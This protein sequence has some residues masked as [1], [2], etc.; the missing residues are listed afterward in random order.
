MLKR[1]IS[2]SPRL[3]ALKNDTHRLIYTWLIPFL[4]VEGRMEADPRIIK[5]YICPLLDHITLKIIDA[6]LHDMAVADLIVLYALNGN[7]YLQLQRFDKHQNIRKDRERGSDIPAPLPDN[8]R[9]TPGAVPDNSGSTPGLLPHNIR[10]VKRREEKGSNNNALFSEFKNLYPK[11]V[12]MKPAEI[13][14]KKA[15]IPDN[16]ITLLKAQIHAKAKLKTNG[17]FTPDW[18]D[19]ER[20]IKNERW[21]DVIETVPTDTGKPGNGTPKE[22]PYVQCPKC[23]KEVLPND[24]FDDNCIHC[25]PRLTPA[26]RTAL[27]MGIKPIPDGDI[28]PDDVPFD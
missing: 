10:E 7:N 9:I 17:I 22:T 18:P 27:I 24:C 6:A 11:K 15:N 14:W 12:K 1:V 16:I 13:E 25:A 19:P 8:S 21:N 28:N 5:G 20:W 4:D 2:T 26:A 3:A 23:K